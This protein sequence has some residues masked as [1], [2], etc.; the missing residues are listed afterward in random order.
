MKLVRIGCSGWM[1]DDWRGRLFPEREPK[2]RW[3]ELYARH[4]DTV[5]VNSTFYRLARR[6]AVLQWVRQT[7][8]GFDFAVK[9]SRY[10][11]HVKRLVDLGE[12]IKRFYETLEPLI[13][14]ARLGPS[15]GSSRRTSDVMTSACEAGCQSC[16]KAGTRSSSGIPAGSCRRCSRRSDPTASR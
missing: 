15:C 4:F 8:A 10:L 6:E 16:P 7:P 5:E 12:G 1:Y 11:T 13:E 3:L 14:A 9:A 2:R